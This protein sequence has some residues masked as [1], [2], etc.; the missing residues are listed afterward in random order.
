MSGLLNILDGVS[1]SL[2]GS[3]EV[4]L[5]ARLGAR[6]VRQL[7]GD[8]FVIAWLN[9]ASYF[10]TWILSVKMSGKL[11]WYGILS[12]TCIGDTFFGLVEEGFLGVGGELL[13]RLIADVFASRVE[14]EKSARNSDAYGLDSTDAEGRI[15]QGQT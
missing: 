6:G 2:L 9:A 8:G 7:L 12:V 1:D 4:T 5:L 13:L 3:V 10:V 15:T 11:T 14:V